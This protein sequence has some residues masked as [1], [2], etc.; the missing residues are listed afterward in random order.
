MCQTVIISLFV[1]RQT[2]EMTSG[3]FFYD[4]FPPASIF[5]WRWLWL[6]PPTT[7]SPSSRLFASC[8]VP[9][10]KKNNQ[11]NSC[12]LRFV[13]LSVESAWMMNGNPEWCA[14]KSAW[15]KT[16]PGAVILWRLV[17]LC[18]R[19]RRCHLF[20]FMAQ[21]VIWRLRCYMGFSSIEWG[22]SMR[23]LERVDRHAT[24]VWGNSFLLF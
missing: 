9:K 22:F 12:D 14:I 6:P 16:S 3:V 18:R 13:S 4:L 7:T 24:G 1:C 11:K 19:H 8:Q 20:P 23:L 21:S 2:G 15:C 10:L 17:K 5:K